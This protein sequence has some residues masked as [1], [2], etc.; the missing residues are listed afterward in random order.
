[1]AKIL[2]KSAL[3]LSEKTLLCTGTNGF[4][5]SWVVGLVAY[6]NE[7][8]LP[9]PCRLI[10]IDQKIPEAKLVKHY[11]LFNIEFRS[12]DLSTKLWP[13]AEKIDFVVHM[14][15]IASPHHYKKRPLETIDV[16][17]EGVRS[18][19]EIARH[20]G[21]K[22]M[23]TSSSE[24]YQTAE[25]IP[26]PETYVG[27][28]A[29]NNERSC[30]DVSKLMGENLVYVYANNLG[31]DAVTT[32]IFNSFGPGIAENDYRILPRI[33]SSI[34]GGHDL[35]VFVKE[36]QP[37]R[38]YCPTG[39]TIAGLFMALLNGKTGEIYNIGCDNPEVSVLELLEIIEKQIGQRVP[40]K[41]VSP[42]DVYLDE[43]LRRCPDITKAR[44]ELG[45]SP[46]I[47]LELGID[48]FFKWALPRYTGRIADDR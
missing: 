40:R 5:G 12:H 7:H 45:Y 1:M 9:K 21:A 47:S 24:V 44:K 39:N 48:L 8:L 3:K 43:P 14:A 13:L 22:F 42:V 33:A 36:Q 34:V 18:A 2:G 4:L 35:S 26:T 27:A 10:G 37:T 28:I 15:G 19:L 32:R 31:V 46:D 23:F 25:T 11:A 29:S 20:S 17:L 6:L 41:V 38:T 30:Y 16:C